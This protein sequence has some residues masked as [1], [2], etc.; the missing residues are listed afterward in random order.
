MKLFVFIM[1]LYPAMFT[2]IAV[3]Y[4]DSDLSPLILLIFLLYTKSVSDEDLGR[5]EHKIDSVFKILPKERTLEKNYDNL[6]KSAWDHDYPISIEENIVSDSKLRQ[7]IIVAVG[8]INK[9]TF[10]LLSIY[11]IFIS[12]IAD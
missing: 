6:H 8:V 5:I 2:A 10:F 4:V 11:W 7:N 9:I 1:F 12:L 3:F